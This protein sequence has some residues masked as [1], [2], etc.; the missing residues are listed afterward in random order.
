MTGSMRAIAIERPGVARVV[1]RPIPAPGPGEVLVKVA[2]IGL[3]GTD[4]GTYLGKN[5]LV[6][7]PR[8][9]GHEVAGVIAEAGPG[10]VGLVPGTRVA[11][12]PYKNCGGC[13]AC[14][15]GRPNACRANETLGVQR[16][17]AL[18]DYVVAPASRLFTSASLS[19]DHLALVE[20]FSVGMHAVARGRVAPGD[21]VLVIGC[22]GVGTGAVA[23]A[24]GRGARV[25][26]LDLDEAKLTLA[27]T[28]G[29]ADA[30]PG[31]DEHAAARIADLTGGDGPS[32]VIEA[33]GSAATYRL[34]L[35]VVQSCGRIVCI[36]WVKGDVSLEARHLVA[37]EVDL[38]GSRNAMGEFDEV[39]ALFESGRIDPA[40]V[41]TDRIEMDA[42][43]AVFERWSARPSAI[44]KVLVSV[45]DG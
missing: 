23:G 42:V 24:A 9:I 30:V 7:Y 33:V 29:A 16:E 8:V 13:P 27:R 37:K 44:G 4:L 19:L 6:S 32:V 10:T 31:A 38:L 14:R 20:P 26:A 43:P 40:R 21:T 5:P 3:C 25:L 39:I 22:G 12:S 18:A 2:R 15:A 11:V 28:L 45:S 36:G 35:E 34:A 17:G 41:V 1:E